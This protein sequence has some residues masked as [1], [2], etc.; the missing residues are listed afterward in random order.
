MTLLMRDRLFPGHVTPASRLGREMLAA[1]LGFPDR[2]T[3]LL[4][5]AITRNRSRKHIFVVPGRE[6]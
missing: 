5:T 3:L 6:L 2:S 4:S 1:R